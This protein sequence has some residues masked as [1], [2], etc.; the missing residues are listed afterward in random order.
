MGGTSVSLSSLSKKLTS[1]QLLKTTPHKLC[2]P[3]KIQYKY[4][5]MFG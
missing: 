5:L 4:K 2:K 3:Q 1:D